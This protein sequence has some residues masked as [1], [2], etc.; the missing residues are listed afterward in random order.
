ML[1]DRVLRKKV[2]LPNSAPPLRP[3]IHPTSGKKRSSANFAGTR[4]LEDHRGRS[5]STLSTDLQQPPSAV[6]VSMS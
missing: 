2:E 4:L 1:R 6:V 3:L 5:F